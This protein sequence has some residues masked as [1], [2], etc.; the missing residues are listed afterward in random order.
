MEKYNGYVVRTIAGSHLYGCSVPSS[1]KDF[2]AVALTF[3]KDILLQ[4]AFG[5][6]V[7]KTNPDN[8][9]KNTSEDVDSETH[10]LH[11]YLGLLMEGQTMALDML[12]TPEEFIIEKSPIWDVI[13]KNRNKFLHRGMT[14]F[15]GYCQNQANKYSVKGYRLGAARRI[16]DFIENKM[17]TSVN[18][19]SRLIDHE[20]GL[21]EL[22]EAYQKELKETENG[23]PDVMRFV[24]ISGKGVKPDELHLEVCGRKTPLHNPLGK[25][26]DIYKRVYDNYGKRSQ[27]AEANSAD[28]KAL[29]HAVR[30]A[31]EALELL[32]TGHITFPRPEAALLLRIRKGE[33]PFKDVSD[34][35]HQ[36]LVDVENAMENTVLPE[37][38]DRAYAED[39]ICSVYADLVLGAVKGKSYFQSEHCES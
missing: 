30:V 16:V 1:D 34:M 25:A 24:T 11:R 33:V 32:K 8:N 35:I 13:V 36:G 22:V 38:P 37:K 12:F 23:D 17:K 10:S 3:P 2:K 29:Y 4:R 18:P 27:M 19:F 31:S 14:S 26:H 5:S 21:R 15:V 9:A 39:L 20:D 28:H 6:H 7:N